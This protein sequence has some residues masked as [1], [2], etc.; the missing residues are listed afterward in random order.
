MV[1]VPVAKRLVEI[2][3]HLGHEPNR[4]AGRLEQA[5]EEVRP[6]F[7][8]LPRAVQMAVEMRHKIGLGQR[9]VGV[10]QPY[11]AAPDRSASARRGRQGQQGPATKLLA[12]RRRRPAS[13][14][15]G[16]AH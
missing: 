7:A 16:R 2:G 15:P 13:G 11:A 4:A 10:E 14:Q 5:A 1:F 12:G 9:A 8:A 3:K 6:V